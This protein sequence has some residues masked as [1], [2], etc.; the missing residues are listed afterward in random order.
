MTDRAPSSEEKDMFVARAEQ[1]RAEAKLFLADA[2]TAEINAAKEKIGLDR[3]KDKRDK[4]LVEDHRHGV[5]HFVGTVDS[6]SAKA[7]MNEL[8]TWS[9]LN[10]KKNVTLI[11][12]SPG[13]DV[14]SGL[15]LWDFLIE[16]RGSGHHLT[17]IS[18]GFAASMAG[19][20]LQAG[21]VRVIGSESWILIHEASFGASGSF[22]DVEDRVKWIEKIQNRFL[23]IFAERSNLSKAQIKRRWHRTDWWIDSDEALKLGFVDEIR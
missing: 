18:R 6:G 13:G 10:P 22:G 15:A 5:F 20:L 21:D 8:T 11:F 17:T 16:L 19:I 2:K 4:E 9:R 14:V 12:N 23:A 7:L 1:A 3:E